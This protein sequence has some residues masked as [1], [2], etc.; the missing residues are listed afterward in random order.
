MHHPEEVWMHCTYSNLE[1]WK[2]VRIMKDRPAD[3]PLEPLYPD[4][5]VPA[6]AKVRD[7]K[8]MA[9]YISFPQRIF[10]LH[11]ADQDEDGAETEDQDSG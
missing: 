10:C 5:L 3:V 6:P 7:L 8:R 1:P 9:A 4:P 2:K 11:M